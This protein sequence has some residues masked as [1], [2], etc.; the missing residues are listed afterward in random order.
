MSE[1]RQ[2]LIAT[3]CAMGPAGLNRGTSGNVSVRSGD[4]FYITPTG[5]RYEQLVADDIPLMALDG[6]HQGRRKPSSE[7]R[8]HRDLY[9][10][11]PEVGAVL[12]AHSPFAVSLACLRCDI[13]AFHYM[14]ARFG[15]DSIR[16]ADYAIFGSA[17]LS[18]AAMSAMQQR[19]ACLLA[20]HGL[21]VAGRDLDE[22]LALAVELEELCEQYWRACQLGQP[23]LLSTD[24]MAAVLQKFA[25]YGQQ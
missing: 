7:W 4:S 11:R 23:V 15:G 24:E 2:Q 6:S 17:E 22:A 12:H 10:A 9:A 20:N 5:M 18:T 25:G 14:I 8:F 1:P 3:A 13:P 21:L 16:C 19:K